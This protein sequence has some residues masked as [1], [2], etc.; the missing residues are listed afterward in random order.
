MERYA[1][2]Q[3]LNRRVFGDDRVIFRLDR[4]ALTFLL[5]FVGDE[6]VGFKVGYA[7]TEA[8]FYSAKGGVLAAGFWD[9]AWAF[10][11]SGFVGACRG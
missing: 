5:A 1:E 10:D 9:H 2:V 6:P 7:E 11:E 8:T 4:D 3:A